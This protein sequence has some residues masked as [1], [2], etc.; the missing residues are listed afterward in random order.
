MQIGFKQ[1]DEEEQ[2]RN[3]K[4]FNVNKIL[5]KIAAI[6]IGIFFLISVAGTIYYGLNSTEDEENMRRFREFSV[7]S[8][9]VSGA[10]LAGYSLEQIIAGIQKRAQTSFTENPKEK[11]P[12]VSGISLRESLGYM[13]GKA[14][15]IVWDSV[16][17][18]ILF[19]FIF[20][21]LGSSELEFWIKVR[22]IL[23]I[24]W[25]LILG[26]V[27]FLIY[28]RGRN[29]TGRMLRITKKYYNV[30][31]DEYYA[32]C[33]EKSLK[34]DMM[35]RCRQFILTGEFILGCSE[36]DIFFKPAA[37][38]VREVESA[39]FYEVCSGGKTVV[40]K[41]VLACRLLNGQIVE[42][43]VSRGAGNG[44]ICSLLDYYNFPYRKNPE[45][46]YR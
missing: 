25:V 10:I 31:N 12:D 6:V 19:S 43:Y 23:F 26:H 9:A 8:L 11:L 1:V 5:G 45:I 2:N 28:Y 14:G 15:V 33:V 40:Y 30:E 24:V 3:K 20:A 37:I 27:L 46:V 35:F 22:N 39:E 21:F 36:S 13:R 4:F 16:W 34:N 29:Y 42:F 32:A 41:G 44:N 38:P 17:G 7:M 18:C